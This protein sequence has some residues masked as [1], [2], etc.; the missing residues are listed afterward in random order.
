M[1]YDEIKEM[2]Q[3]NWSE[4]FNYLC[5]EKTKIKMEVNIV[6]SMKANPHILNV[7][8]KVNFFDNIDVVSN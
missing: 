1:K 5:I 8:P 4:K 3:K 6:F 7:F 2:C